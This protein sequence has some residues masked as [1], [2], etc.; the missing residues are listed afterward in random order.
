MMMQLIDQHAPR[1]GI[2]PLCDALNVPRASY[3]RW[4]QPVYGPHRPRLSP[5]ALSAEER[6]G[7]IDLLHQP[8]RDIVKAVIRYYQRF[9]DVVV[10]LFTYMFTAILMFSLRTGG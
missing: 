7:V 4:K 5:R 6:Q 10:L 1:H 3:Y 2:A 8:M 9:T